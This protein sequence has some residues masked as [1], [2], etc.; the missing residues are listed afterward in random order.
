MVVPVTSSNGLLQPITPGGVV[1][2]N[3]SYPSF[4]AYDSQTCSSTVESTHVSSACKSTTNDFVTYATTYR[5]YAASLYNAKSA[6]TS[7]PSFSTTPQTNTYLTTTELVL[8]I[9]L[10]ILFALGALGSVLFYLKYHVKNKAKTPQ[11]EDPGVKP[12][13]VLVH[14]QTSPVHHEML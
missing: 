10:P 5:Y 3:V 4:S 7:V 6:P 9:V 2:A 13:E 8:V 12:S 1:F 11:S 14:T